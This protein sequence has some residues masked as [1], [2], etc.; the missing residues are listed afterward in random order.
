[1]HKRADAE[2]AIRRLALQWMHETGYEPRPGYFPSFSAF[3]NWLEAN[4]YSRC[5]RFRSDSPRSEAEG[6]FESE[7][8]G[9]WRR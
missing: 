2:L 5:L 7:I 1:M 8:R 3:T 9:Y 6:W 4:N